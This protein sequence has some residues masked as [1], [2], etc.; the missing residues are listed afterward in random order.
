MGCH[1]SS[2]GLSAKNYSIKSNGVCTQFCSCCRQRCHTCCVQCTFTTSLL[3]SLV[4]ASAG[5]QAASPDSGSCTRLSVQ[6]VTAHDSVE[7]DR[8]AQIAACR[9]EY[10]LPTYG[11][12]GC[13][14]NTDTPGNATIT[15]LLVDAPSSTTYTAQRKLVVLPS[16]D[17]NEFACSS[18]RCSSACQATC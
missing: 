8:S 17:D 13:S 10:S 16:C 1:V 7:G 4:A 6:G 9:P 2:H 15:Y 12:Q 18:L 11:L 5:Y 14:L 3:H